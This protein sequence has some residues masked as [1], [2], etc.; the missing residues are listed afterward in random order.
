M[1]Q[2]YW[3]VRTYE[4]GIIGE[5]TKFWVQGERPSGKSRRKEKSEIRKQEQNEYS[6]LKA[7]ARL[8]NANFHQDDLILGMDYSEEGLQKITAWA[9]QQ[10]PEYDTLSEEEQR[11][12]ILEA[13]WHE[14]ELCLRRV[15][16]AMK[17]E[18][19]E[20][21]YILVTSDTD[22]ET[23]EQV[24]V[25]HHLFVEA[26]TQELFV[27]KWEKLG[28]VDWKR[29]S[30]QADYTPI[31]EYFLKQVRRIPDAK[32]FRGSRNLIRPQPKD[33]VAITDAELRVPKGGKLLFRQEYRNATAGVAY[34][35]QYIRYIIPEDKRKNKAAELGAI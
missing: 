28:K 11:D 8:A 19:D 12:L 23:G 30:K 35:P 1:K 32:K 33:R 16:R 5:K 25:H 34:Q 4:A 26:G 17:K 7:M 10:H 3:V 13:A 20:L 15:A 21:R 6:A 22:G 31:A 18:G 27:K 29:I 9:R 2:G 24:R 14:A